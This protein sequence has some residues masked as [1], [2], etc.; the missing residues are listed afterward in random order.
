MASNNKPTTPSRSSPA[1]KSSTYPLPPTTPASR[2]PQLK[3]R[4]PSNKYYTYKECVANDKAA[5]TR[6]KSL[7]KQSDQY[8]YE[9]SHEKREQ[10]LETVANEVDAKRI[11]DGEHVSCLF[12]EEDVVE[13]PLSPEEAAEKWETT[14]REIAAK[15]SGVRG[16]P[17]SEVRMLPK[18]VV[19]SG[20]KVSVEEMEEDVG[21]LAV[22][23][24][25]APENVTSNGI[26][27]IMIDDI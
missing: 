12:E 27:V 19:V 2:Q 23:V 10:I 25:S 22:D 16:V 26:P 4:T 17:K 9:M 15:V 14:R 20:E 6:A 13:T 1:R 7:V 8:I 11:R 21:D 5:R 24:E 18:K 3:A